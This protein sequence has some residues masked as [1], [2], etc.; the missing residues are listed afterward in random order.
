MDAAPYQSGDRRPIAVR[1]WRVFQHLATRLA[2]LGVSPNAISLTGMFFGLLAGVAL[3][4]TACVGGIEQR[5][6]WLAAAGCIQLRLL[7]NMLDGM[8]AIECSR[9]SPVGELFNEIPD[10]V[11]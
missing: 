10:R 7:A 9:A 4:L 11:S 3:G 6:L 8:V 2:R 1:R 5:L